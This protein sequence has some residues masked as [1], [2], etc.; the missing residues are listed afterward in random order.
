VG[1]DTSAALRSSAKEAD[2]RTP[3]LLLFL[4][5]PAAP[6]GGLEWR[7][8]NPESS[9]ARGCRR[10]PRRCE[11]RR[12]RISLL[13]LPAPLSPPPPP[14]AGDRTKCALTGIFLGLSNSFCTASS[15]PS[16]PA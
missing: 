5:L 11:A 6:V 9:V 2:F 7:P 13:A 15:E 12:E 8:R 16:E 4:A 3:L 10:E 14:S 1:L